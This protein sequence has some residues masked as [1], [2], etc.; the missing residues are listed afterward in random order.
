MNTQFHQEEIN[1]FGD[2]NYSLPPS[3]PVSVYSSPD[4]VPTLHYSVPVEGVTDPVTLYI[5]RS[6][7][8]AHPI[9]GTM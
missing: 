3:C 9:A 2:K 5:H 6:Q 4:A 1:N 7:R 8:T